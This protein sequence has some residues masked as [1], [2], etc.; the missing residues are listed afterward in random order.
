MLESVIRISREMAMGKWF[1]RKEL[2]NSL[3]IPKEAPTLIFFPL[4]ILLLWLFNN[5]LLPQMLSR[6]L[7]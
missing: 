2:E 1:E 5:S 4:N 6:I 3:A 7:M